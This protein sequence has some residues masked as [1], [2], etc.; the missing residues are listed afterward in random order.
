MNTEW[1]DANFELALKN[2]TIV[3]ITG[4]KVGSEEIEIFTESG[5]HFK[6]HHEQD[7]CES[8]SVFGVHG[9]PEPHD[10]K[11]TETIEKI[12]A[13]PDR[14]S[15]TKTTFIIRGEWCLLVIEWLGV[16]NGYYSES[17]SFKESIP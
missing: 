2:E 3:K 6:M 12:E 16:S 4:C 7:C 15:A 10:C 8:V 5:R 13:Y 11:V 17:V 14:E 1:K 9:D